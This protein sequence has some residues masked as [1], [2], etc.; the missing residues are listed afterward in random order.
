MIPT[1]LLLQGNY[2]DSSSF[3]TANERIARA[4]RD[5]GYRVTIFPTTAAAP[6]PALPS[7]PDIYLFHGSNHD[8]KNAPGRLNVFLLSDEALP[9][10]LDELNARFDL[11]VVSTRRLESIARDHGVRIPIGFLPLEQGYKRLDALLRRAWKSKGSM[12][13]QRQSGNS[14]TYSFSVK[15]RI[16][17]KRGTL[18]IDA[19]LRRRYPHYRSVSYNQPLPG[20]ASDLVVGQ[21]EFC[22]E[23]FLLSQRQNPHVRRIL[24]QEGTVLERRIAITNRERKL[25]GVPLI[26][27][28]PIEIWR[29]RMECDL[30]DYIVVASRPSARHFLKA[31]YSC[32]KIRVIPWGIDLRERRKPRRSRKRRFL[33]GGT[34]PFRKGIRLLFEAWNRLRP[35][36]AELWCYTSDEMLQS[37]KLLR[38]V[39][40]NPS[41]I[42][43]P[44]VPNR[45]FQQL[46]PEVDCQILPSLEDS[47][48]LVIGDG[49][50]RGV[51]AIV[52]DETGIADL[53]VNGENGVIV[54]TGSIEQLI[55]AI[56]FCCTNPLRLQAMGEAAYDTA[57]GYSWPRFRNDFG[58]LTDSCLHSQK[59]AAV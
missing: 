46:I 29:N 58:A 53:M 43:R 36:G 22:L 8:T 28:P 1:S 45:V 31:G 52:S 59:A 57:R 11:M 9:A 33:F 12:P 23:T 39:V 34:E 6:A 32:D 5:L 7:P 2:S 49:M 42:M 41:I 24:H 47:F 4:L 3:S 44:L 48:S 15:G 51:P 17:W 54:R 55:S 10:R 56:D 35:A 16:S 37:Q 25:C 13:P 27:K 14:V 40:A 26:A 20:T 18:E 38:Y 21:S 19:L 50:G 30:A